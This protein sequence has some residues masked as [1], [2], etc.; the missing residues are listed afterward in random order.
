MK[1]LATPFINTN[2]RVGF[3]HIAPVLTGLVIFWLIVFPHLF[4]PAYWD[5]AWSYLP[6]IHKM[7]ET[8]PSLWP[9]T[10]PESLSKGHPLLFFFAEST[11]LRIF[12]PSLAAAKVLPLIITTALIIAIFLHGSKYFGVA[13][14]IASAFL[15][16]ANGMVIAQ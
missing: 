7:Y 14:G 5:E 10:I 11:W 4:L 15:L 16:M 2:N 1:I 13:T 3:R 9:G 12:G 6:A 8:H